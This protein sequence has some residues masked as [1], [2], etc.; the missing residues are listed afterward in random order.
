MYKLCG[1]ISIELFDNTGVDATNSSIN[2]EIEGEL[3]TSDK[4]DVETPL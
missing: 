3:T 2:D 1:S 4:N